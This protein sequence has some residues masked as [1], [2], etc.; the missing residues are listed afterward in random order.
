M[1]GSGWHGGAPFLPEKRIEED[2]E[3]LIAEYGRD[4]VAVS[5]PPPPVEELAEIQLRLT[6]EIDDHCAAFRSPDVLGALWFK[7]GLIRIDRSLDPHE[8]PGLLGRFRFTLAHEVR[9]WR[10]HRQ[11]YREDP[12]Q[13]RL[14]DGRGAPAFVCRSSE[15]P[16]VEWQADCFASYLMMPRQ[17]L[18]TSWQQWRGGPGPVFADELPGKPNPDRANAAFETFCKPLARRFEVSA[19]ASSAKGRVGPA[20]GDGGGSHPGLGTEALGGRIQG[21]RAGLGRVLEVPRPSG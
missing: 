15:K 10:L 3:S 1:A 11:Y 8:H 12:T 7:D 5:Q 17:L 19:E 2:A 13:A 6:M 4:C 21:R 14:F 18:L 20:V 9:H 16:P